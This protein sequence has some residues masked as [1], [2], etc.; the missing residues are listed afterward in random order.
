M[1]PCAAMFAHVA[2]RFAEHLQSFLQIDDVDSVA[3]AENVF[4]HLRIPAARLVAEVNSGLQKFFHRNFDSQV[5]SSLD[6]CLRQ[7]SSIVL[8]TRAEHPFCRLLAG[9][10]LD[11]RLA[12]LAGALR[13]PV[14]TG[15]PKTSA[16]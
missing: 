13:G 3:F 11:E 2:A 9:R 4:L 14:R 10:D 8:T 12:T 1:R 7:L 6:C 5:T 16:C 15:P